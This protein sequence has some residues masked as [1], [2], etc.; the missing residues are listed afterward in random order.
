MR[1]TCLEEGCLCLIQADGTAGQDNRTCE[2]FSKDVPPR[3]MFFFVQI[4]AK[5]LQVKLAIGYVHLNSLLR[6]VDEEVMCY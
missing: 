6:I 2:N 3:D 4:L 5:A 1:V